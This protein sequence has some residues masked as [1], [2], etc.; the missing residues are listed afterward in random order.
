MDI[1]IYDVIDHTLL[2]LPS[3]AIL[4]FQIH[5]NYIYILVKNEGLFRLEFTPTQRLINTAVFPIKMNVNRFRVSQDGFNDDL[6]I[7]FSNENTV[8]QYKWDIMEAP[9]MVTKYSLMA[10]SVV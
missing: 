8:Y 5:F 7:I 6:T 10:G 9:V 2:H 1:Q 4:D 3:L